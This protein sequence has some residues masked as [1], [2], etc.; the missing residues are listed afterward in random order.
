VRLVR[1][2]YSVLR[3]P[4]HILRATLFN[5]RSTCYVVGAETELQR[6]RRGRWAIC[7][8]GAPQRR[9]GPRSSGRPKHRQH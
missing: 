9:Q 2:A 4:M 3:G 1:F 5:E 8:E 7:E 6:W